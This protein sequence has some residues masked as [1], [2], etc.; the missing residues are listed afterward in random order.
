M[1]ASGVLWPPRRWAPAD[2]GESGSE[3]ELDARG[4]VF[5]RARRR[6]SF[7]F[8]LLAAGLLSQ[9]TASVSK[10]KVQCLTGWSAQEDERSPSHGSREDAAASEPLALSR[11]ER[12]RIGGFFPPPFGAAARCADKRRSSSWPC[13]SP[14]RSR[15]RHAFLVLFQTVCV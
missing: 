1:A 4:G 7:F 12:K 3:S 15:G 5:S 9:E 2:P 13:V 11:V 10:S 14:G 8:L 6:S